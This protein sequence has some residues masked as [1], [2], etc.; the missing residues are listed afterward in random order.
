MLQ[1]QPCSNAVTLACHNEILEVVC[2]Y[3]ALNIE[4]VFPSVYAD[5]FQVINIFQAQIKASLSGQSLTRLCLLALSLVLLIS[6]TYTA[7]ARVRV[8]ILI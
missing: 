8:E 7:C 4:L 5:L 3:L 2:G 1:L 6:V